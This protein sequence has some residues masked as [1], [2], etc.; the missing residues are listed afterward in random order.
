MTVKYD[1]VRTE[2]A[3]RTTDISLT[4]EEINL[5][6]AAIRVAMATGDMAEHYVALRSIDTALS[7]ATVDFFAETLRKA[8]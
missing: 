8:A 5:M 1:A 6:H 7:I 2:M 4:W 3:T